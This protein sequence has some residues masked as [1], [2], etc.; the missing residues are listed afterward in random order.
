MDIRKE[1]EKALKAQKKILIG[2]FAI[3]M[4]ALLLLLLVV[5]LPLVLTGCGGG[6]KPL[7]IAPVTTEAEAAAESAKEAEDSLAVVAAHFHLPEVP[8]MMTDPTDQLAFMAVHYW[9][10]YAFTDTA[11][12]RSPSTEQLFVNFIGLLQHNDNQTAA[13]AIQAM[14]TQAE[15]DTVACQRFRNLSEH[16]FYNP[17]SPMRTEDYYLAAVN[18]MLGSKQLSLGEKL[19][20]TDRLKQMKKNRPGMTAADFGFVTSKDKSSRLTQVQADYTLLFFY[21][22]DCP[23][24]KEGKQILLRSEIISRLQATDCLRILAIYPDEDAAEWKRHLPEMPEAWI[25]GH[26]TRQQIRNRQLYDL[27]A[28]PTF[29]LFDKYKRVLLKD[30]LPGQIEHYLRVRQESSNQ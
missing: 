13:A 26:D 23:N 9:N 17:N 10:Y 14:L 19:R 20:Y 15:Q 6:N 2:C 30:A 1:E 22:P 8:M 18:Q 21:D 4:L 7:S 11:F 24:C 3:P 25:V 12:V 28:L 16:Y 27:R 29:Y 5:L